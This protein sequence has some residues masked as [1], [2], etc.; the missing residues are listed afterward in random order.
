M[1]K[2]GS[3]TPPLPTIEKRKKTKKTREIPGLPICPSI[4]IYCP[5][6][7]RSQLSI[8]LKNRKKKEKKYRTTYHSLLHITCVNMEETEKKGEEENSIWET[9]I[10][11]FH[12]SFPPPLHREPT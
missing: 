9:L 6:D 4:P 10:S 8:T 3:P 11:H 7:T 1:T 5:Q 12:S 2:L